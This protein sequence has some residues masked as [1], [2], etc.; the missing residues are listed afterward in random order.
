MRRPALDL[1][2]RSVLFFALTGFALLVAGVGSARADGSESASF[3]LRGTNGFAVDVSSQGGEVTLI[4]SERRP[5]VATFSVT[6]VPRAAAVDNGASNTYSTVAEPAGP[7]TVDAGLGALGRIAVHFRPSGERV[8]STLKRGCGRPVRVV[9]RLGVFTGTIRFEGEQGYT[10]VAATSAKGSVGTPLPASCDAF[11][12]AD[13]GA[14]PLLLRRRG[15]SLGSALLTA[16]DPVAGSTFRAVTGPGGVRFSAQV[17]ER[18]ADGIVVERRAEAGAPLAS[19]AFDRSLTRATVMPP[20]PF[21][22]SGHFTAAAAGGAW[23]GTLRVT[24]PGLSVPLTGASFRSSLR[25]R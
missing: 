5:P 21:S 6:G 11:G 24:F 17:E 12:A 15:G 1:P 18:N 14:S 13:L 23:R 22:G 2:F 20:A 9:R 4:A 19:F 7:G 25:R 3:A 8:V 10:T 16:A